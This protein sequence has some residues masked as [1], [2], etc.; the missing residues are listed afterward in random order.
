[1]VHKGKERRKKLLVEKKMQLR[2]TGLLAVSFLFILVLI[3]IQVYA[4]VSTMMPKLALTS[5]YTY[6]T[7]LGLLIGVEM[8][9]IILVVGFINVLLTHRL[10]GPLG[11]ITRELNEMSQKDDYHHLRIR[12]RDEVHSIVSEINKII[13]RTKKE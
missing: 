6:I 12:K 8:L 10:V 2:H 13:D 1:M 7:G 11:R 3:Q 9:A 4:L 5:D